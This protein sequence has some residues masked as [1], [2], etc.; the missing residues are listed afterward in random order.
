LIGKPAPLLRPLCYCSP[1][2]LTLRIECDDS[3]AA[4]L[5]TTFSNLFSRIGNF[6]CA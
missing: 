6:H 4:K 5:H 3:P 1:P 2:L